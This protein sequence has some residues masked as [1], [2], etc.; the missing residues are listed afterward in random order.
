M[1]K[2][3]AR[4]GQVGATYGALMQMFDPGLTSLLT[5]GMVLR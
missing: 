4:L 1:P 2:P 5:P 3:V